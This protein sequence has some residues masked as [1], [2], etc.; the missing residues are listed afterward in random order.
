MERGGERIR[1]IQT[2]FGHKLLSLSL[3]TRFH[4]LK[5]LPHLLSLSFLSSQR[6]ERERERNNFF[7]HNS[8]ERGLFAL[9]SNNVLH[10][11]TVQYYGMG[12]LY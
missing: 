12:Y 5:H 10:V 6:L 4:S 7:T 11:Q 8:L 2:T 9:P 3:S 1:G